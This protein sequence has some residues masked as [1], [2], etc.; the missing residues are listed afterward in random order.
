[1]SEPTIE[2]AALARGAALT[3]LPAPWPDV[4]D[5]LR[6]ISGANDGIFRLVEMVRNRHDDDIAALH[7]E[8]A[9]LRDGMLALSNRLE[10]ITRSVA[11]I[12]AGMPTGALEDL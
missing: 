5:A 6:A 11:A 8:N 2:Q 1:V 7:A 9:E 12:M 3:E 10:G 4:L